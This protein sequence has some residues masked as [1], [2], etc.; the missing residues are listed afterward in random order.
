KLSDPKNRKLL[1]LFKN[2]ITVQNAPSLNHGTTPSSITSYGSTRRALNIIDHLLINCSHF[3]LASHGLS[4]LTENDIISFF[5]QLSNSERVNEGIYSWKRTVINFLKSVTE[6]TD[7]CV[8]RFAESN[9]ELYLLMTHNKTAYGLSPSETLRAKIWL[10]ENG[11]YSPYL[12]SAHRLSVSTTR[13]ASDVYK[14]TLLGGAIKS[15]LPELNLDPYIGVRTEYNAVSVR[16][17]NE[18]LISERQFNKYYTS[19]MA[20]NKLQELRIEIPSHAFTKI[21]LSS[22]KAHLKLTQ[23]M[24]FKTLRPSTLLPALQKAIEF[25]YDYGDDIFQS[26]FAV[27]AAQA[28]HGESVND[29]SSSWWVRNAITPRLSELGVQY[30]SLS[31]AALSG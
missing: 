15:S 31:S 5:H 21:S 19:F 16:A 3:K 18:D 25:I 28:K 30:W 6:H 12:N 2:W 17:V 22:L 10:Y 23:T 4:L 29:P 27:I 14:N 7:A 1:L 8:L 26:A 24:R 13:L 9:T 20:I 11:Y